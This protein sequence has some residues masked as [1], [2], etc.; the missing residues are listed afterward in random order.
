MKARCHRRRQMNEEVDSGLCQET[1]F[2]EKLRDEQKDEN[3]EE[4]EIF[5]TVQQ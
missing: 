1:F 5:V 4:H 3:E 2:L